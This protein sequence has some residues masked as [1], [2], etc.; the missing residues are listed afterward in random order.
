MAKL[1]LT[2]G[3]VIDTGLGIAGRPDLT[4]E[5]RLWLNLFLEKFYYNQ[6]VKWLEKTLAAQTLTNGMSLPADYRGLSSVLVTTSTGTK[7]SPLVIQSIEE[8]DKLRASYSNNA[9][10]SGV[11]NY[12]YIDQDNKYLYFLPTPSSGMTI[13]I[14]Y[15]Y[16]PTLTDHENSGFDDAVP[17][18]EMPYEI[19]VKFI[20]AAAMQ[21]NDDQRQFDLF[22]MIDSAISEWKFNSRDTRA[23]ST[24]FKMGKSFRKRF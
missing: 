1:A 3:Q 22:K 23:S 13:D 6:D 16:M 20:T 19:L 7:A 14:S 12:I 2:H 11:P 18:W 5:A 9:Q 17:K 4:T 15:Y 21:Y 10:T 24:R 8:Y